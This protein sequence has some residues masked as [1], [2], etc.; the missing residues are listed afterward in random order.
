MNFVVTT[1]QMKKAEE[2]SE[3]NGVSR[4]KLMENAG[5]V[6]FRSINEFV[7][8][9][10]GKNFVV[11][12][13]RGNNGGDGLEITARI[14]EN[15]GNAVALYVIDFPSGDTARKCYAKYESRIPIALYTHKEEIAK[16]VLKNANI[17][18][19]CVFGT[20][21]HGEL[22]T[23]TS[24]L[25]AFINNECRALRFS[26]DIPSGMNADTGEI[27]K[28][29]F[30]PHVTY[31]LG[32]IKTGLLSHPCFD[33]CGSIVLLDIGIAPECFEQYS[34]VLTD[35][36]VLEKQPPR[37][38]NSHKGTF[39]SLL[40]ISG[41]G[42][43]T[44]AALLS[45]K[46][47]LRSGAGLVTLATPKRVINAIASA[48]P[49]AVFLPLE[50][51]ADAFMDKS[52]AE[53]L[54]KPLAEA[55]VCTLGCGIGNNE[56]S[57]YIVEFVLKNRDCPLILDA[58]GINCISSNINV[59]KDNSHPLVLTPHPREFSRL[60][61]ISVEEVQRNRLA[62]AKL[63]A[64]QTG[65]VLVLKGVNTVIAAPDGRVFVNTTGNSAL[66]KAGTGDVLTGIIGGLLAQGADPFD[67]AV[68]G[69]FLHGRCADEL[70]KK[71]SPAG[72]LAGDV[73]ELLPYVLR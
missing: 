49:E 27:A 54:T 64:E 42:F 10:K 35:A 30:S 65:T 6:C 48:I 61:G 36:S 38:K 55:T 60:A 45:T 69:V 67:C 17:I 43:Y 12:C 23:G 14:I 8:G 44:G 19:D 50:Q 3:K 26:I 39:G 63:F 34:A 73:I 29:A 32:A 25:F 28:N 51:D 62:L 5:E 4:Q 20:G 21:F 16:S 11:L 7:G 18:V 9:V 37:P 72:I 1:E 13:G 24:E 40:N 68:L 56:N 46:A 33:L 70:V 57:R 47:A 2:N 22:E 15:G 66:A 59:L 31:T 53:A 52:A 71:A 41:S 58:D